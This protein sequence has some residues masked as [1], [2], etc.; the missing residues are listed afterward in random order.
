MCFL[1]TSE[2][3]PV[4]KLLLTGELINIT[5]RKSNKSQKNMATFAFS[6]HTPGFSD[7]FLKYDKQLSL[8]IFN[9][10]IS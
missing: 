3:I 5:I 4:A 6:G 10:K 1:S 2:R 8:K 9:N 7:V